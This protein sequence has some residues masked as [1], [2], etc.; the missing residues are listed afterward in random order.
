MSF[1]LN[2]GIFSLSF[3]KMYF[4]RMADPIKKAINP[5]NNVIIRLSEG[6]FIDSSKKIANIKSTING[7]KIWFFKILFLF[8]KLKKYSLGYN[9][10]K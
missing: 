7:L 10:L 1:L 2:S 3:F 9:F 4:G 5:M 8:K 6:L